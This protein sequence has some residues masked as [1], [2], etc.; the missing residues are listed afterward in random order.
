[1][2]LLEQ[3]MPA[4][5][6][7]DLWPTN[8]PDFNPVDYRIWSVVQQLVYQSRVHDTDELKQRLQQLWRNV[9]HHCQCN[10]R[11]AQA[12]SCMRAGERRTLRAYAV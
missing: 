8:S 10:W 1:V 11:V 4:F 9:D 3:A 2:R 6:P 5:I 7:P 12:S